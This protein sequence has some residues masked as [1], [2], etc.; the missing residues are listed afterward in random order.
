MN[1]LPTKMI[2]AACLHLTLFGS[3]PSYEH[4]RVFSYACYPNTATT[5]PHKLAPRS[6]RGVFLG[7]S[8][9]KG[10]HCFDLST[11]RLL[12]SRHVV[13]DED[14]IPLATSPI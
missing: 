10:Y 9:H 1:R 2:R 6:T 8:N 14:S 12:V 11:N 13:F 7:Y 3:A 5:A 4:L